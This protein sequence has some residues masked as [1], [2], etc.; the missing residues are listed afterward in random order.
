MWT[1]Q[2]GSIIMHLTAPFRGH[3][4]VCYSHIGENAS[5]EA[6]CALKSE[7][8]RGALCKKLSQIWLQ[9]VVLNLSHCWD[10]SL[11]LWHS[12]S[13]IIKN[14]SDE[15][16][17][18]RSYQY[19]IHCEPPPSWEATCLDQWEQPDVRTVGNE[20]PTQWVLFSSCHW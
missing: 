1:R 17:P 10:P 2:S 3:L 5:K 13:G 6:G 20:G 15:L 14:K 4:H 19:Y 9:Q 11:F 12:L 18:W 8:K 7:T 16:W